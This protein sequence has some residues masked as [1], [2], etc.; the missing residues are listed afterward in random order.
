MGERLLMVVSGK[1]F[2]KEFEL[3]RAG[4]HRV[5]TTRIKGVFD[6]LFG[7]SCLRIDGKVG[8]LFA[9][10]FREFQNGLV[11]HGGGKKG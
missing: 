8:R 11:I 7:G 10:L 4:V 3:F 2:H 5:S 9:P 1:E 6:R